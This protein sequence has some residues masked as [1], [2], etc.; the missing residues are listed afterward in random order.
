MDLKIVVVFVRLEN[1]ISF[2]R[3]NCNSPVKFNKFQQLN[4]NQ[5]QALFIYYFKH[6]YL[7]I[8]SVSKCPHF[9]FKMSTLCPQNVYILSSKCPHFEND[10]IHA[11]TISK[12]SL[13]ITFV[14][15]QWYVSN[16]VFHNL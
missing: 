7:S 9:V 10:T 4:P 8:H 2:N 12:V 14:H 15:V 5:F 13:N 3:E 11:L 6:G 16:S 1:H